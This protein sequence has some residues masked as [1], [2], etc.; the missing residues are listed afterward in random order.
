MS[1]FE[2]DPTLKETPPEDLSENQLLELPTEA[3]PKRG[4][5]RGPGFLTD[6]SKPQRSK[7]VPGSLKE[8]RPENPKN[9]HA[10]PSSRE[11]SSKFIGKKQGTLSAADKRALTQVVTQVVQMAT[12]FSAGIIVKDPEEKA[13]Q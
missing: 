11:S 7:R 1:Q 9:P 8:S 3:K 5:P 10:N 6:K 2:N 4:R 13:E 12:V